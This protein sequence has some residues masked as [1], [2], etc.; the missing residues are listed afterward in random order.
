MG[1]DIGPREAVTSRFFTLPQDVPNPHHDKRCKYGLRGVRKFG[2]GV[3][4]HAVDYEQKY[5][6][7]GV[8][9]VQQTTEYRTDG[10][11]FLPP[12]LA[13]AFAKLDPRDDRGPQTLK[14]AAAEC[15]ISVGCLCEYAVKHL[16]NSGKLTVQD[17][18]DA[19]DSA[20]VE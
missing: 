8:E 7:D 10:A 16:L 5:V 19:Y 11:G 15:G 9:K 4:V 3:V 14:E 18:I 17:V 12:D 2:A 1:I 13:E 20:P 6:I